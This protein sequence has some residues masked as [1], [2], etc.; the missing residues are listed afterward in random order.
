MS[1]E[2]EAIQKY[3]GVNSEF[4][5]INDAAIAYLNSFFEDYDWEEFGRVLPIQIHEISEF[6]ENVKKERANA[7]TTWILE[8][9][10]ISVPLFKKISAIEGIDAEIINHLKEDNF[11]VASEVFGWR[12]QLTKYLL[13]QKDGI[14][15]TLE[16]DI[17]HAEKYEAT[18]EVI[19]SLKN[20]LSELCRWYTKV[21]GT[22]ASVYEVPAVVAYI[23]ESSKALEEEL[24]AKGI[25]AASVYENAVAF[26]KASPLKSLGLYATI[27]GYKDANFRARKL[28]HYI[29]LDEFIEVAGV[30]YYAKSELPSYL[31]VDPKER[32]KKK[33]AKR[34]ESKK[35]KAERLAAEEQQRRDDKIKSYSLY[36][37]KNGIISDEPVIVGM[38]SLLHVYGSAVYYIKKLR[39]V[40]VYDV[41]TGQDRELISGQHDDFKFGDNLSEV[42]RCNDGARLFIKKKIPNSTA[43]KG[44]FSAIAEF[45]AKL[46]KKA[47]GEDRNDNNFDL[48]SINCIDET[49]EVC[50][51]SFI[52]V[53][54][55]L[56]NKIFY[57]VWKDD[58][59]GEY[60]IELMM[61]DTVT[62]E[63][64]KLLDEH[65]EIHDVYENTLIYSRWDPNDLNKHLH[66]LNLESKEDIILERNIFDFYKL[67]NGRIYY[68]VGNEV[69]KLL[70]SISPEGSDRKQILKD[71]EGNVKIDGKWLYSLE[72]EDKDEDE[73]LLLVKQLL[74]GSNKTTMCRGV[75]EIF[76]VINGKLFFL[77]THN[78]FCIVNTD[79]SEL[80]EIASGVKNTG[81]VIIDR[82]YIY[83]KRY[84]CV[85]AIASGTN[86]WGRPMF[87]N[88]FAYSLYRVDHDGN[89]LVK[90]AFNV[91]NFTEG[92]DG[93]LYL[94]KKEI[95]AYE[96]SVPISKK[97]AVVHYENH[98][99]TR[100]MRYDKESG[101]IGEIVAFGLPEEREVK[102]KGCFLFGKTMMSVEYTEVQMR[103]D[104]N[105]EGNTAAGEVSAERRQNEEA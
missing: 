85:G 1:T 86:A 100:F 78:V 61:R 59:N 49:A 83:F 19:A 55:T 63:V 87:S 80:R 18:A 22:Y 69:M 21:E 74:D 96:V 64:T 35:K 70:F 103:I 16:K 13:E 41:R 62:D 57:T 20:D 101:D 95:R 34:F 27:K 43:A 17:R 37:I 67:V 15:A 25:N 45:F 65:A 30:Q 99:V 5:N 89:N 24:A 29:E 73:V 33:K 105:A 31:V 56:K 3:H 54:L 81:D 11:E 76:D 39:S 58:G 71:F 90:V 44:C 92:D 97:K 88:H 36:P 50:E 84:E 79:G 53:V 77:N 7:Y 38:S 68:T 14:I 10:S 52:D 104:F 12:K 8:Y 40:C 4:L 9:E 32:K 26:E 23:D 51:Y 72:Y 66:A 46:F 6:V 42:I 98:E 75:N 28:N 60:H 2:T 48:W 93:T 91:D 82:D 94:K 102:V 47:S